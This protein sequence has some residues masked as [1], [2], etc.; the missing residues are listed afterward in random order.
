VTTAE[1][2]RR[3][4]ELDWQKPR[5]AAYDPGCPLSLFETAAATDDPEQARA[6]VWAVRSMLAAGAD[7]GAMIEARAFVKGHGLMPV[8]AF[9]SIV[10]EARSTRSHPEDAAEHYDVREGCTWW[11]RLT[12]DGPIPVMLATFTAEITDEVVLD[13]GA[14]RT[15]TWRVSVTARDGRAG[16]VVIT[17]DHLGR[18]QM[19]AAKAVGTSALVMPGPAIA[20][21]LRVAVQSGSQDVTRQVVYTHTG[22]RRLEGRWTY[23]TASGALGAD[24]LDTSVTVD[25]GPLAGYELPALPA[26]PALREAIRASLAVLTLAADPVMVPMLA[27]VYRAPLPIAPD[28]SV[29]MFGSSGTFKTAITALA[30]QHFGAGMDA[31][32]LPGNWT[33]TANSLEMQAYLL[34]HAL[35]VVDDFSPDASKTDAQRRG[36]AANRLLRGTGPDPHIRRGCAPGG[37]VAASQAAY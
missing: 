1:I 21:H 29:W 14:E 4:T 30:Q 12:L 24:G 10:R 25:L 20:D 16:E 6:A 15:L 33:S 9:D 32:H 35:Y 2:P 31:Q 23:L 11:T 37:G 22:W 27:T 36:T 34:A 8:H 28:C 7:T 13:D 17:P 26:L 5:G 19:W 18:P 3:L